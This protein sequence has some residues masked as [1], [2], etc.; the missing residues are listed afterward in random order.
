MKTSIDPADVIA[1][2]PAAGFGTRFPRQDKGSHGS[3]EVFVLGKDA[4]SEPVLLIDNLLR[5][6]R[7]GGVC[8]A[9]MINRAEKEDISAVLGDGTSRGLDIEYLITSPTPSSPHT[10]DVAYT[11]VRSTAVLLGSADIVF[12]ANSAVTKLL[13]ALGWEDVDLVLGLTPTMSPER[14]DVVVRDGTTV[15]KL[16]IKP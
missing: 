2:I 14:V 12:E 5:H 1:L 4:N 6:L 10:L 15:R 8:K 3:K 7:K 9:V 16:V 13:T 11:R